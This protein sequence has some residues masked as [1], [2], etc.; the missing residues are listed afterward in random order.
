M[1]SG[2]IMI[3]ERKDTCDHPRCPHMVPHKR[4]NSRG[5]FRFI[6]GHNWPHKCI[7]Y[8]SILANEV[9]KLFEDIEL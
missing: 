6:E 1:T 8:S 7:E 2:T 3:C 5:C 9:D 4:C